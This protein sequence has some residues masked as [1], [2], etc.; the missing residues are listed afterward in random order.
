M[1]LWEQKTVQNY[2]IYWLQKRAV[3]SGKENSFIVLFFFCE[4]LMFIPSL[5]KEEEEKNNLLQADS[6]LWN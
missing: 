2:F 4:D 5:I 6:L 3:A 1:K